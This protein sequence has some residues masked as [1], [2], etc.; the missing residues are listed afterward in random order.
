MA[1]VNQN[2]INL[3]QNSKSTTLVDKP[4][5]VASF[6]SKE[7]NLRYTYELRSYLIWGYL[8]NYNI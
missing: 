3:M 6:G 1:I 4:S 5:A 8:T 2:H 7:I